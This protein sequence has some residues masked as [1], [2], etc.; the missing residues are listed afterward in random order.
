M[1]G[2]S[3]A[4]LAAATLMAAGVWWW[5]MPAPR[6]TG[7]PASPVR[8]LER[9]WQLRPL[10]RTAP[11]SHARDIGALATALSA[12]LRSGQAPELAWSHVIHSWP[13]PLPGVVVPDTAEVVV[14]RRWSEHSGW[15]GLAALAVCWELADASG[16]GLA[17]ALDRVSE[18]MRHEHEVVVEVQSQLSSVRATAVTLATLP[19]VAVVM[20]TVL[21]ADPLDVL[22]GTPVGLACLAF[23]ATF[24]LVGWW[25][26]Q[27]QVIAVRQVLRW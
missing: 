6:R 13:G 5:A 10:R 26:V 9:L 15:S 25:W 2:L 27:R 8:W 7:M 12:E 19:A 16:A 22:L 23:G 4:A 18:A 21:G 17:D 24:A 14:L 1:S 20:G 11:T 3:G